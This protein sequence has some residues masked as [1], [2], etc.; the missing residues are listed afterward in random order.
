M[1]DYE[2]DYVDQDKHTATDHAIERVP[3]NDSTYVPPDKV[4]KL[5]LSPENK[6]KGELR[7]MFGNP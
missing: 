6:V 2:R 4:E 7:K 5:F 3:T 1:S